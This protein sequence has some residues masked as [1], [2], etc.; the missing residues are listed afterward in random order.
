MPANTAIAEDPRTA[1]VTGG[2]SGIGRALAE[3]LAAAGLTVV[4]VARDA[5]RG[6]AARQEIAEDDR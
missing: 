3:A 1:L 4:L 5:A 2:T 6:E